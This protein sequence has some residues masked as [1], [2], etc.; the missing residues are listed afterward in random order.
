MI[1]GAVFGIR[2]NVGF[3]MRF[4]IGFDVVFDIL[5]DVRLTWGSTGSQHGI[6]DMRFNEGFDIGSRHRLSD[7]GVQQ[8]G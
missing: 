2:V 8:A 3:G 6:F 5:A 7:V 1:F 4:N